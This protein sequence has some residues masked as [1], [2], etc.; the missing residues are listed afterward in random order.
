[1]AS[2]GDHCAKSAGTRGCFRTERKND[3]EKKNVNT[4]F[5]RTVFLPVVIL[6][7][8]HI[9]YRLIAAVSLTDES[10]GVGSLIS[11]DAPLD[12]IGDDAT[13]LGPIVSIRPH[14]VAL[15]APVMPSLRTAV[16]LPA[17]PVSTDAFL[18]TDA[19]PPASRFLHF[20]P[21]LFSLPAALLLL[22]AYGF[23]Q[24]RRSLRELVGACR[25]SSPFTSSQS[26][27]DVQKLARTLNDLLCR[28][29]Q[30]LDD[31]SSALAAFSRQLDARVARLRS[32]ALN[33]AQWH[34]RVAFIEDI[35][36]FSNVA[37]QF[38][39]VAGRNS[40][41]DT[42]VSVDAWLRDRFFHGASMDD[43]KIVL[44]L[45][46]G[47]DFRLPHNSLERLVGN[48]VGNALAHGAAP[49]EICTTHGARSWIL[50]V[51]DH[52]NGIDEAGLIAAPARPPIAFDQHD[53]HWGL[54]L[55][56][57]G[58]LAHDCGAKLKLGN[59][60]EGGFWARVIV[61][62]QQSHGL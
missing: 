44:R 25:A 24:T 3:A 41:S 39:D 21:L 22:C 19:A 56:I 11:N 40:A 43:A 33:V 55:S 34:K 26:L 29:H 5:A 6:L 36:L 51:R 28:H 20:A 52:G 59:H 62:D 10:T 12:R 50:S 49:I 23:R 47:I 42:Q 7:A 53:S 58:R 17:A 45:H 60:P 38:V 27:C 13:T 37:R 9:G 32:R 54:G 1:M 35:E 2:F 57:V 48:L 4:L 61:P 8:V 16:W 15:G 46:A 18:L 31:Y 30:A 14:F